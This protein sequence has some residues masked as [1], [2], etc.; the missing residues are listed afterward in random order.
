[1]AGV[2]LGDKGLGEAHRVGERLKGERL[3]EIYTSPLE[4]TR[5]T[6]KAIGA[7]AGL[8]PKVAEDLHEFDYGDWCGR[9]FDELRG[10]PDWQAWSADRPHRR[11]PAG[12]TLAELQCR[13]GRWLDFVRERHPGARVA[14]VSHSEPIKAALLW[15]LGAPLDAL[16]R[17]DIA[18]ASVS[19]VVAGD[20]GFKV[21]SINETVA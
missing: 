2:D 3:S 10:D 17:F 13:V 19:V 21:H 9:S 4:R 5:A 7:A 15:V 16:G 20:W 1:M 18:P 6:A 11:P 12:E 14:A 8:D